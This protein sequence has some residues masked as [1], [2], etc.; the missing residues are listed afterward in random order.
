MLNTDV[1][2]LR[3]DS[4]AVKLVD[5]NTNSALG[6]VPDDTSLTMVELVRHTLVDGT[7]TLDV[8]DLTNLSIE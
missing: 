7:V 2:T 6:H 5:N 1:D 8:D 4:V 3:D